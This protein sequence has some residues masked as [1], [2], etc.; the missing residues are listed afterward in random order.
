MYR[1]QT[2][3]KPGTIEHDEGCFVVALYNAAVDGGKSLGKSPKGLSISDMKNVF[4]HS[5]DQGYIGREGDR[6]GYGMFVWDPEGLVNE[7]LSFMLLPHV[8]CSYIGADFTQWRSEESWGD[9]MAG[10]EHVQLIL[11]VTTLNG[12]GHFRGIYRDPWKPSPGIARLKS[13]RYFDFEEVNQ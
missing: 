13:V 5:S 11:Q 1:H 6:S 7:Y 9:P 10:S 2:D 12:G 3:F 4:H 8:R